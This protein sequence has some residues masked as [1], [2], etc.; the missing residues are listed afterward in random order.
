MWSE[1]AAPSAALARGE[2][3]AAINRSAPLLVPVPSQTVSQHVRHPRAPAAAVPFQPVRS[4]Y[5]SAPRREKRGRSTHE[6]GSLL[7]LS[8]V[9]CDYSRKSA[10]H[11]HKIV[12]TLCMR[13]WS[14]GV[15][16]RAVEGP[17]FGMSV[18]GLSVMGIRNFE[19]RRVASCRCSM[20]G[21]R[22][23]KAASLRD[24]SVAK[25]IATAMRHYTITENPTV[26]ATIAILLKQRSI[27]LFAMQHNVS[28]S[29]RAGRSVQSDM[30]SRPWPNTK[31][32]FK[33]TTHCC[34]SAG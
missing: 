25:L 31:L 5:Q 17:L 14:R 23:A 19:S 16:V 13:I 10:L 34:A 2:S 24:R 18:L 28:M 29:K 30:L 9:R 27:R 22:A 3:E 7:Q 1:V 20:N 11:Q 33:R 21:R 6:D 4:L 32:K 8:A 26:A 12:L 15:T